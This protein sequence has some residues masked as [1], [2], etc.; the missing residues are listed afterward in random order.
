MSHSIIRTSETAE[1]SPKSSRPLLYF[2][3]IKNG[4]KFNYVAR[5]EYDARSQ[6]SQELG[7]CSD[8]YQVFP[9]D[10]DYSEYPE[11]QALKDKALGVAK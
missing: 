6:A 2:V 5:K 1:Q 4:M 9:P 3:A 10:V 8:F 7:S 11:I